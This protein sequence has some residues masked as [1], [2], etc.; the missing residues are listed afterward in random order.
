ML[1][2]IASADVYMQS[3]RGA[4]GRN[5]ERNVN[6]N[7]A[8]RLY[9]TQNN[10]KGGYAAPRAVGGPE[11]EADYPNA[12]IY[13]YE[14]EKVPITWTAQHG[15]GAG[16]NVDG[17]IILQI[18]SEDTFD[19]NRQFRS[20]DIVGAPRDGIPTDG[21]D[22]ATDRIPN[23]A[24]DAVP[25]TQATRRYG[26]HESFAFYDRYEHTEREKGLYTADQNVNRNDAR[27][28]R[29][30]PNG[31]RNGLEIPEE[32]DYYP[33][34]NPS[35][36]VDVA[37]LDMKYT[38]AKENYF[39]Q[40]SH[41]KAKGLCVAN[42]GAGQTQAYNQRKWPNNAAACATLGADW[43][44]T[45]YNEFYDQTK[46]PMGP[47]PVVATLAPSTS[48]HLGAASAYAT[49]D[50]TNAREMCLQTSATQ[51]AAQTQC[52]GAA[53][54]PACS[55]PCA[56]MAGTCRPAIQ[57]LATV[58][59][60]NKCPG[61]TVPT[62][63]FYD[64]T[65]QYWDDNTGGTNTGSTFYWSI[66]FGT[67]TEGTANTV[68]RMRYNIS[69]HDFPSYTAGDNYL[70]AAC[71]NA[72]N[73]KFDSAPGVNAS[74]N[75]RGDNNGAGVP[76]SA[77][78]PVTQDPYIQ[79]KGGAL[80]A[81]SKATNGASI[82]SLA[83]N[84]NQYARTFQDRTYIFKIVARPA[85][86]QTATG[87]K[88]IVGLTVKGKRGN[89][90]QTYPAVEYDFFPK[91]LVVDEGAQV[92]IQWTGSDYN[93]QRGCNNGEGGPPDCQG[94]RT[95]AQANNAANGNSRADRTNLVAMGT[96]GRNFPAGATGAQ[97]DLY[98]ATSL[99]TDKNSHPF[100]SSWGAGTTNTASLNQ[101]NDVTSKT[102]DAVA[103]DLMY[104]GQEAE[105]QTKFGVGC[106]SQDALDDI[107]N[108]NRRENTPQNCA[109]LNGKA[110][111]YFDAGVVS[112]KQASG[113]TA[114]Q[115][116]TYAF[117]SS[118]NNNFSNRD[119]TMNICVR[120]A[121]GGIGDGV[122]ATCG[123]KK[124]VNGVIDPYYNPFSNTNAGGVGAPDGIVQ[125]PGVI[126]GPGQII[127]D[128]T[129]APIEKDNDSVGSGDAE[130]CEARVELFVRS[131]G[132]AGLVA[133][134]CAVFMLGIMG[135]LVMQACYGRLT[136][137][138][139]WH[140]QEGHKV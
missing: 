103:W 55:I 127:Q 113:A 128:P 56:W 19:P 105:L 10:A 34:S 39:Q 21:N 11:V 92:H 52:S 26:M 93:P 99:Q 37:V 120:A 124:G 81:N 38:V 35:P 15:S 107:N 87:N 43:Q 95:L 117:F 136:S 97:I 53:T 49:P 88:I 100:A 112:I 41:V 90:V 74:Y 31:N 57:F 76:C 9:D 25:N 138:D 18:G 77:V 94:C 30:N 62:G 40:N 7:N 48:N 58:K 140:E 5:A 1:L 85:A 8:N 110:H 82:L 84:T 79:V 121:N 98:D 119:Q 111:P 118:R 78:S 115:G 131:V 129:T 134:A 67:A 14:G 123:T 139:K 65:H 46:G 12:Q 22:A 71:T 61:G 3:P 72:Q 17:Q 59:G 68:L 66:P 2:S 64:D 133:I 54:K 89:I 126:T 29:Q 122:S 13:Y 20:G 70:G 137:K 63:T 104:I 114:Q 24:A 69:T 44:P 45:L 50:P 51:A 96:A 109:K 83:L 135:T 125:E 33:W 73:C 23:N 102:A 36:W 16:G 4:N 108:Q 91:E 132:F 6:R 80:T 116:K 86:L 42:G 47:M 101:L 32:R 60:R 75:C 106:L 28:T 27:G 130:A